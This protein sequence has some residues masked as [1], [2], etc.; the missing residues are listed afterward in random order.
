MPRKPKRADTSGAELRAWLLEQEQELFDAMTA[1]PRTP[2]DGRP[3][4]QVDPTFTALMAEELSKPLRAL[5][6]GEA[7]RCRRAELPDWHPER[8]G[9]DLNDMFVLNERNELIE[10]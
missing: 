10:E 7:Y 2:I 6:A 9:D 8:R 3:P 1:P 4:T 5:A